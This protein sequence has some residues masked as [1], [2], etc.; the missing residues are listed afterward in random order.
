M[1]IG[2]DPG[3]VWS[4]ATLGQQ[5]G[6]GRILVLREVIG[7]QMGAQRLC[8]EKLKPLLAMEFPG[9]QLLIAADPACRSSGQTDEKSV[10]QVVREEMGVPVRPAK[11]NLIEPRLQAVESFL[12]RLTDAGPAYLVDEK[13][14][15]LIRGFKS[16]Y[17]YEVSNKGTQAD[18]P[19]K[20]EYSHPHDAN[21]YMCMA[22]QGEEVRD[23]RRRAGA[24]VGFARNTPNPY[25]Y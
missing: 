16:G 10:A 6:H 15:T 2:F 22:F 4:A 14:H 12:C 21:Q 24:K 1:I 23:A 20:N 5:D 7:H 19:A 18:K 25:V 3:Y 9:A 13:C 11:T 17:R 8:R